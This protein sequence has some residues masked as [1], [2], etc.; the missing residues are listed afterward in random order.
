[1]TEKNLARNERGRPIYFSSSS[2]SAFNGCNTFWW[3]LKVA[4]E[5][6]PP[7]PALAYGNAVHYVLETY[8]ETGKVVA[9]GIYPGD[10]G[11]EYEVTQDHI[12]RASTSF[13]LLPP[14]GV[15]RV[16]LWA[17]RFPVYDGP[18]GR[19]DFVGKVDWHGIY[20]EWAPKS[21]DIPTDF[22]GLHVLDHKTKSRATGRYGIPTP[23]ELSRDSQ[24]HRYAYVLT[25]NTPLAGSDVLF[26]HNYI[27][28]TG[29]PHAVRVD[30]ILRAEDIASTWEAQGEVAR[31]M[32]L[33]SR[34]EVKDVP[35][36]KGYC[37][38]Y[39]R[40]CPF[41]SICPAWKNADRSIIDTL[42]AFDKQASLPGGN[43]ATDFF[44]ALQENLATPPGPPSPPSE[45]AQLG[46]TD[47]QVARM[48]GVTKAHI[49]SEGIQAEGHVITDDGDIQT[50]TPEPETAPTTDE[51]PAVPQGIVPEDE[52]PNAND[53]VRPQYLKEVA[54][55]IQAAFQQQVDA[56]ANPK[57]SL[58]TVGKIALREGLD[59]GWA[60]NLAALSG[61]EIIETDA[62]EALKSNFTEEQIL[63]AP[64]SSL[65]STTAGG[66]HLDRAKALAA[67]PVV[68]FKEIANLSDREV[69]LAARSLVEGKRKKI[70]DDLLD[71]GRLA[72]PFDDVEETRPGQR[73]ALRSL[74]IQMQSV[75]ITDDDIDQALK[76]AGYYRRRSA[77]HIAEIRNMLIS[78]DEVE[79]PNP[80][81]KTPSELFV[82]DLLKVS[83]LQ[84]LPSAF[85]E[86]CPPKLTEQVKQHLNTL[87]S[88]YDASVRAPLQTEIKTLTAEKTALENR[89]AP[90]PVQGEVPSTGTG[91]FVLLAGC[92]TLSKDAPHISTFLADV[93]ERTMKKVRRIP[94]HE[95][96]THWALADY[97]KGKS[98]FV[99]EL[100][101]W[102]LD[103]GLPEGFYYYP[104]NSIYAGLP[105]VE[106][107]EAAGATVVAGSFV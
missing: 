8:L 67:T 82:A 59:K 26:S 17:P 42:S 103:N 70:I 66:T 28:K 2:A 27:I 64:A 53:L 79:Q 5:K 72:T 43:M 106:I 12:T 95:G 18:E 47:E 34:A 57:W 29:R 44:S 46:Y 98:I 30:T 60:L 31:Q 45:L 77:K 10:R 48:T 58:I 39:N 61:I 105:L 91:D 19:M 41:K 24:G 20:G 104:R 9:P 50:A 76:V 96:I 90:E 101:M 85:A 13:D 97:N 81:P 73:K 86:T 15:G 94:G 80:T 68:A 1:M 51:A 54:Q 22:E 63:S 49:V 74:W 11:D 38:A 89:P 78:A 93:E 55:T 71:D 32:I 65:T 52:H 99:E 36:N 33:A 87:L 56:G 25:Q 92:R 37:H 21:V 35:H 62:L 100:R 84:A 3:F 88:V 40:E 23:E 7:S 4:G 16:E 14:P 107:F 6:E 75:D 102:V 69:L 83:T